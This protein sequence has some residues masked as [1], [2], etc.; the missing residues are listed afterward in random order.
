M[1][2]A[3]EA[4]LTAQEMALSS[5][6]T[7]GQAPAAEGDSSVT[8]AYLQSLMAQEEEFAAEGWRQVGAARVV[9]T[10]VLESD[11]DSSPPRMVVRAC[12]DSSGVKVLDVNGK[13]LRNEG[14]P[15][16]SWHIFTLEWVD[17]AWLVAGETFDTDPK[18]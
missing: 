14:T 8:G 18:C 5:P 2:D 4:G 10:E 3:V 12:V 17:E 6:S 9:D 15:E 11:V 13:D 7:G 16:R 1:T